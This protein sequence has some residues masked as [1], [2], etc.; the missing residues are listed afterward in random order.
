M[1]IKFTITN[2]TIFQGRSQDFPVGGDDE[3]LAN[4]HSSMTRWIW[5]V[6]IPYSQRI[7]WGWDVGGFALN[8]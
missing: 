7:I 2:L 3:I 5:N 8:L 1:P 4:W 6:C